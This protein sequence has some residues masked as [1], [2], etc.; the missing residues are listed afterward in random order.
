MHVCGWKLF[1]ALW[2]I[3]M[4]SPPQE[5]YCSVSTLEMCGTHGSVA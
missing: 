1:T 5:V 2:L 4:L 3:V